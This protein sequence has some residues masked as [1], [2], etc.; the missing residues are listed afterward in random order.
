MLDLR[1][2]PPLHRLEVAVQL[3]VTRREELPLLG[4]RRIAQLRVVVGQREV[5][6]GV[7][8]LLLVLL[9]RRA[10]VLLPALAEGLRQYVLDR[11]RRARN[12]LLVPEP[13]LQTLEDKLRLV[14]PVA[15]A[16]QARRPESFA[17]LFVARVPASARGEGIAHSRRQV[18]TSA[19]GLLV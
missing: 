16:V 2:G 12:D 18:E 3:H 17:E 6:E 19:R 11:E 5:P 14:P 1:G 4:V 10:E 9:P 15:A 13:T 7:Q 8:E